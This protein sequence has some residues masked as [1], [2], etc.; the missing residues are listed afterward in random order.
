MD[1]TITAGWQWGAGAPRQH[2]EFDAYQLWSEQ[3]TSSP[4]PASLGFADASPG[5][6]PTQALSSQALTT[7]ALPSEAPA[8][9]SALDGEE[10]RLASAPRPGHNTTQDRPQTSW[11]IDEAAAAARYTAIESAMR[12]ALPEPLSS[13]DPQAGADADLNAP[14]TSDLGQKR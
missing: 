12:Q 5:A 3:A 4:A 10:T 1:T 6:G 11:P 2:Y 8:K 13:S 7:Q 9:I 14:E